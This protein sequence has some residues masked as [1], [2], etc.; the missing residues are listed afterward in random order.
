MKK[1]GAYEIALKGMLVALAFVLSYLE[2]LLPLNGR[3]PGVK[4]G[5]ANIVV[6]VALYTFGNKTALMVSAIRVLLAGLTFA[7]A[8]TLIF[9]AAGAFLSFICMALLKKYTK[10]S[11]RGVNI[12]G[13][14]MHNTAQTVTAAILLKNKWILF[15]YWPI[16]IVAGVVMGTITGILCEMVLKRIKGTKVM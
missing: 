6:A 7:N 4:L 12:A 5:I 1:K 9:S 10:A 14:V 2:S 11:V 15:N 3:L 16:L 13:A 8:Y